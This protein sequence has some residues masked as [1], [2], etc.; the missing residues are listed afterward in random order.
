M[1]GTV[2]PS[3]SPQVEKGDTWYQNQVQMDFIFFTLPTYAVE[4]NV[5]SHWKRVTPSNPFSHEIL[6]LGTLSEQ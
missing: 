6:K 2:P 5:G 3:Q 4:G 1:E